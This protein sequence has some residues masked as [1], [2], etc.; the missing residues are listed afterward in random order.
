[1]RC[2]L[3]RY[4]SLADTGHG[5]FLCV[6]KSRYRRLKHTF[7]Y[8]SLPPHSVLIRNY[9][10]QIVYIRNDSSDG[11]S[12]RRGKIGSRTQ[13]N[14][15]RRSIQLARTTKNLLSSYGPIVATTTNDITT[16][17]ESFQA[18][19]MKNFRLVR[20]IHKTSIIASYV[21]TK[22]ARSRKVA[23]TVP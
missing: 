6:L 4:S 17:Q 16:E 8:H 9:Y 22:N 11:S 1:M 20:L 10:R 13:W 3:G 21:Y 19:N 14:S 12:N 23:V 7:P 2:P 15:E 18:R 5:V